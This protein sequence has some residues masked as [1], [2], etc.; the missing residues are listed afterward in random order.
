[1]SWHGQSVSVVLPT[2]NEVGSI[3]QCIEG[4]ERL[5]IVDEIIV[6]NNNAA[7]GTS[8]AVDPTSARE[9]HEPTQGYGA[10]IRRGLA[11]ATGDL[12]VLCEPD[13]TFDPADL[14]KLLPFTTDTD[15]VFGSRTVQTFIWHGANMGLFLRWGN[16]AVAKLIEAGFGTTYLS[17][18]GCT[19]R[20]MRRSIVQELLPRFRLT[21]SAFGL[22]LLMRSVV[23]R[24]PFVQ[25]P[26]RYKARVGT[27]AVT[28]SQWKAFLLGLE[29]IRM[30]LRFRFLPGSLGPVPLA[31][32]RDASGLPRT[33]P[34]VGPHAQEPAP[35]VPAP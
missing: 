7:H 35:N 27:S 8:A 16:W 5:G 6:V 34:A 14:M 15:V 32:D 20:V 1:M 19:F 2:Y 18:V 10:A 24:H 22:E 31:P 25:V 33:V 11:E 21:G 3:Q 9:V 12:V 4:F 26:V 29:M 17:D 30:I 13:G 28:G 23:A